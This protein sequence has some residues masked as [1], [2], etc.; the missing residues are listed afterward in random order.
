M[1][2]VSD[3]VELLA[4]TRDTFSVI[5]DPLVM[6]VAVVTDNT[7]GDGTVALQIGGETTTLSNVPYFGG[8]PVTSQ[9]IVVLQQAGLVCALGTPASQTGGTPTPLTDVAYLSVANQFTANQSVTGYVDVSVGYKVAGAA[10]SGQYLRGD[11]TKAV[12]SAIQTAD[13]PAGT[14]TGFAIPAVVLGTAAAAG[15]ATTAIRSDSTIIAFDATVPTT[16][17]TGDSATAG[18]VALAARRDHKHGREAQIGG[19]VD[20]LAGLV[21]QG[22]RA[23]SSNPPLN[24]GSG[25]LTA[26][27]STLG[28]VTATG[29]QVSAGN[30]RVDSSGRLGLLGSAVNSSYALHLTATHPGSATTLYGFVMQPTFPTTT[31]LGA[32]NYQSFMTFTSG[33]TMSGIAADFLT[34]G[35]SSAGSSIATRVA[36]YG[37]NNGAATITNA[38]GFYGVAT[39]GAVTLNVTARFDTGTTCALWLGGNTTSTTVAGGIAF[40]SGRDV[41]LYRSGSAALRTNSALTVDGATTLAA[42]SATSITATGTVALTDTLTITD[43]KNVVLGSTT[44]T[45]F[46]TATSQKI[47]FLNATPIAQ[48]ANSVDLGQVLSD[49][50]FRAS[51]GNPPLDLGTGA[52]TAKGTVIL[53]TTHLGRDTF[54]YITGTGAASLSRPSLVAAGGDSNISLDIGAKGIGVVQLNVLTGTGTGGISSGDGAGT[55]KFAVDSAGRMGVGGTFDASRLIDI[56]PAHPG[57]AVTLYSIINTPTFP[58]TTT[59]NAYVNYGRLRTA[60]SSFT[61]TNGYAFHAAAPTV[62][63]SSTVT[64]LYGLNVANQ[65]GTG[66]TNAYGL[67]I[68]AQSGAATTNLPFVI[69]AVATFAVNSSGQVFLN[70]TSDNG[71]YISNDTTAHP[72]T[73]TTVRGVI[74]RYTAPATATSEN[75]LFYAEVRTAASAFTQTNAY[76]FR[77]VAPTLGASSAVT[78][79]HGLHVANL[80]NALATNSYGILVAAQSGSATL[81]IAASLGGGTQANLWLNSDTATVAGGIAFGTARD[82]TIFRTAS[83]ALSIS[84]ATSIGVNLANYLTITG[85][86]SL[87]WPLIQ[88][89]GLDANQH[90]DL[91]AKGA[92]SVRVN[93]LNGTG[94]AGFLVGDGAGNTKFSIDSAGRVGVIAAINSNQMIAMNAAHPGTG[95]SPLGIVM[96]A[97]YPST[98]T[99]SGRSIYSQMKTAAASFTMVTGYT[100]IADAPSLGASSAVTTLYGYRSENMG[101]SGVTNAY[102]LSVAATSGAATL[103][104]GARIDTGTTCALWLGGETTSTTVAGGIAFG[105][106]R[107]VAFFRSGSAAASI[108]GKLSVSGNFGCN[109]VAAPAQGTAP[110]K[111]VTTAATQTTP[112]GFATQAQADAIVTAVNA[113]IDIV[114]NNGITT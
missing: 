107:D 82:T 108:T 93:V 104:V 88:S 85:A 40:G 67:W 32:A 25:A 50:G 98:A 47:G 79:L 15:V 7:A 90:L 48:E 71:A 58:A 35:S 53:G 51:G 68:D 77:A 38:Y 16:S 24:L 2:G 95:V 23:A 4:G 61:L 54:N 72:V 14:P 45:K 36:F 41:T 66:V 101:V 21:T 20:V 70:T 57:T 30:F 73:G 102:G 17:A 39:S 62:G 69:G 97:A 65:G 43:A 31:T 6:R 1:S 106:G 13:L 27:A 87:S 10:A 60:A 11:G 52:L 111:P 74:F 3:F 12:F 91:G 55:V 28:A 80:G 42:M 37:E 34:Q 76:N 114:H 112:W 29:L 81:N 89:A 105:S 94:T 64:N 26:G 109:G 75:T 100:Y 9:P 96:Q 110:T 22:F 113:L 84:A 78:N 8:L 92:G 56:S 86:A 49:F 99:T 83:A 33:T 5:G 103:N 18:S 63:A 44:G 46:G 59:S 19:A